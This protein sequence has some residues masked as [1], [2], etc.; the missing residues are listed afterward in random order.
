MDIRLMDIALLNP[1]VYDPRIQLNPGDPEFERLKNSIETFGNV[2]P[3]VWNEATGNVVGGHQRLSVLKELGQTETYVSVIRCSEEDEK[4]LNVALN[5]IKGDW[6]YDKLSEILKMFDPDEIKLSGF[7]PNELAILCSD[8][9]AAF[10]AAIDDFEEDEELPDNEDIEIKPLS[11][12]ISTNYLV[13]LT[14][15]KVVIALD[16]LRKHGFERFY[17]KN[18]HSTNIQ[19]EEI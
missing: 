9:N 5:K 14:F 8:I 7:A 1:A 6:D 12:D 2:E 11:E 16:W 13:I 19:I 18:T 3:I 4:L 15:D 17:H 10:E